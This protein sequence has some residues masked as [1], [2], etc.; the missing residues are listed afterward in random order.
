[1]SG[2][3]PAGRL[4]QA[5]IARMGGASDREQSRFLPWNAIPLLLYA[6]A[7][8]I[9]PVGVL[10]VY[11]FWTAEF[12]EVREAF[13]LDNYREVLSGPLYP[14]LLLK[15]LGIGLLAASIMVVAGFVMA[16]AITF[17]FG[18]FGTWLLVLV[19]ATLLASYLVRIYAW[20][21]ILG[22]NGIVNRAL[23]GIGLVDDP[24]TFLFY[25]YFAITVTLVYVY[26][27][28]AVLIIYGSL[29][30]I[31]RRTLEASRDMGAGRW[32]TL[33]RVVVPQALPGIASA[34]ALTFVLA[35]SDYIT[36]SL[37]GGAKGQMVGAV[38]RDQFGGA[39][40][41]PRGAAL[42]FV[43]MV[44]LALVVF[45][46]LI[47]A[48]LIA[49]ARSRTRFAL[50]LPRLTGP[51]S[52]S[53]L[54]ARVS[55]SVPV[56]VMLVFFLLAPLVIV[57]LFSFNEGRIAGLPL[58]GLNAHWYSEVVAREEFG[59]VLR[60][61]LTIMGIAVAGGLLLAVPTAFALARRRFRLQPLVRA[62]VY[63]PVAVPGVV[64]GVALL[65]ALTY[66]NAR[67]G[68][69]PTAL[70]HILLVTPFIVIVVRARLLEMDP[71]MGEA[72][73]DLGA[74]PRRVLST[75]T[76]PLVAPSLLGAA[77][78]AAAVSLDEILVTNFTIGT[79]A[80]LPVW[81][82]GQMRRGLTPGINAL[83]VMILG[84]TLVLIGVAALLLRLRSFRPRAG[85]RLEA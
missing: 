25:G 52:V 50:P 75:I 51:R 74:T 27:P 16:Y 59:R 82:L 24:L 11:S 40:N 5:L 68:L 56:T 36:P 43:T 46:V 49:F 83:A 44:A 28:I 45:A 84:G 80:T 76:L 30:S 1:M 32:S 53:A 72:A 62:V 38:I 78:L 10:A 33:A 54:A 71:S 42:A 61:S 77:V 2:T 70:A 12:F 22:T 20:G 19:T 55:F 39:A 17:R 41:L 14:S 66:I 79:D 31:D 26:L 7:L 60:T 81:I 48:R 64:L 6:V 63:G 73:R 4:T 37:V 13:T 34:F 3:Q 58:T 47:S 85:G 18:R 9:V 57:I 35:A 23:T 15:S 29:Q 67:L 21:T 69:L 8:L 65:T